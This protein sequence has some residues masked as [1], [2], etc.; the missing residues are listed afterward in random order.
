MR[1]ITQDSGFGLKTEQVKRRHILV[2]AVI[3]GLVSGGL[4]CAFRWTLMQVEHGRT[5]AL[6]WLRENAHW[7]A[8]LLA[9]VGIGAAGCALALWLVRRF[10]PETSGSGIPHLKSV[11]LDQAEMRWWRV[12]PVKFAA[13]VIGIGAGLALGREGPTIQMGGATGQMVSRWFRVRGGEGERKA[14]MSAGAAAGLSAAFNAPLAGVMFVLEELHGV[15]APVLFV[16]A[17]VSSVVAD[18]VCRLLLGA[19]P[20]FA[21]PS[22]AAP[23]LAAL[24]LAAVLGLVC[25]F[26]GVAFN[27]VLLRSLDWFDGLRARRWPVIA[28]GALAGAVVGIAA[29]ICPDVVGSGSHLAEHA[30]GGGLKVIGVITLMMLA[31]FALTMWSFGSGAAGGIFAPLLVI[32]ALVGLAT[33][34]AVHQVWPSLVGHPEIFAVIGMGGLLTAIVRAP[35]TSMVL[36]IELTGKYDFMLP[37]LTCS[38]IAYGVAE[39]MNCAPIYES[40]RLRALEKSAEIA[41]AA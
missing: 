10:A 27:K 25:G 18:I 1:H 14:L 35:L 38:L 28:I 22:I 34:H 13:G 32:G 41:P 36:I 12:I 39:A 30:L 21:T 4:A 6:A 8:G 29:W 11:M 5:G 20:V 9:A 37:V 40:L 33:G 2:K 7:A 31:R 26:G 17:F 23:T 16:A 3:I 24:P 15:F 19:S